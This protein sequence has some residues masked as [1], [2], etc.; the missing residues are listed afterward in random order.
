M[1]DLGVAIFDL[2]GLKVVQCERLLQDEEL[3]GLPTAGESLDDGLL[4]GLAGGM[5]QAGQGERV[6]FAS[7]DG[8]QDE[9]TG[10]TGDVGEAV[11]ELDRM[12]LHP[13][14][15]LERLLHM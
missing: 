1:L 15:L 12:L 4:G 6:A 7:D 5:A 13:L 11:V 10:L 2:G 9:Q 14:H 3:F 8:A